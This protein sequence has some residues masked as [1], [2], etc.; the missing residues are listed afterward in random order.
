MKQPREFYMDTDILDK[1]LED[2]DLGDWHTARVRQYPHISYKHLYTKVREVDPN[3]DAEKDYQD[4][5][6]FQMKFI[7]ADQ[8]VI[9][10]TEQLKDAEFLIKSFLHSQY[11]IKRAEEWLEKF[12]EK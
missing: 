5:R 4:M 11:I 9:A 10:L 2:C 8:K 6:K 12:E 7:E 3:S 1:A